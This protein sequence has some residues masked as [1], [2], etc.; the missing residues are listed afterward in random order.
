MFCLDWR[1]AASRNRRPYF[2]VRKESVFTLKLESDLRRAF[3][4][5]ARAN[6]RPASQVVR[7]LMRE[8]IDRYRH[9]AEYAAFLQAKVERARA[10]LAPGRGPVADDDEC[11]A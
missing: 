4:T 1:L 10:Q 9:A 8:Y 3:V 6:D 5:T 11:D 2:G 7:E